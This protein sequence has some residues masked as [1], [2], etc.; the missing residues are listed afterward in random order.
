MD[1]WLRKRPF[2]RAY[3]SGLTRLN[4]NVKANKWY[5]SG[6]PQEAKLLCDD[7]C[8]QAEEGIDYDAS[9]LKWYWGFE[10]PLGYYPGMDD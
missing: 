3:V 1:H 6:D 10:M 2:D 8:L 7:G 9:G 4:R 5:S